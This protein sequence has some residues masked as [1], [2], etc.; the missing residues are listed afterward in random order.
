MRELKEDYRLHRVGCEAQWSAGSVRP[1]H[2]DPRSLG[3]QDRQPPSCLP[4]P[5]FPSPPRRQLP[6]PPSA[7]TSQAN[8]HLVSR[9]AGSRSHPQS[10]EASSHRQEPSLKNDPSRERPSS[11]KYLRSFL[12][13]TNRRICSATVI[14]SYFFCSNRFSAFLVSCLAISLFAAR[15][16]VLKNS[17][18]LLGAANK[19]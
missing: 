4:I 11:G 17:V 5:T 3:R 1:D 14:V 6:P 15:G 12:V 16:K 9:L 13:K 10:S 2:S 8:N 18:A 7:R 19:Q